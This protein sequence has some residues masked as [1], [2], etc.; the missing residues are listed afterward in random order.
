[1]GLFSR[2]DKDKEPKVKVNKSL[3]KA[4]AIVDAIGKDNFITIDNCASRLRLTLKDNKSVDDAKIK[5]AGTFGLVRLGDSALQI[6]IGGD[7]E[8]VTNEVRN[9]VEHK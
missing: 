8:H 5:A 6:V 7:V 3:I 4:Q 1:M 2:K 9:L